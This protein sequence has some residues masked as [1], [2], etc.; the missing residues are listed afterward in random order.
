MAIDEKFFYTNGVEVGI[1]PFDINLKFMRN[2]TATPDSVKE[3]A[4]AA[5]AETAAMIRETMTVAMSPAHAKTML[6]LLWQMVQIYEQNFG[7][8][9]LPPEQRA[10]WDAAFQSGAKK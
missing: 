5:P 6:P 9:T 1:S 4:K 2:G 10:K 3:A 8:I 7:A